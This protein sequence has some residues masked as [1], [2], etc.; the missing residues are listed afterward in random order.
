MVVLGPF[1]LQSG[2]WVWYIV[3][4]CMMAI[5][6]WLDDRFGLGIA[7]RFVVQTGAASLVAFFLL[8]GTGDREFGIA[9][10]AWFAVIV[11]VVVWVTNLYNFMDGMDGLAASQGVVVPAVMAIWFANAEAGDAALFCVVLAAA[12]AG[13]LVV[14]WHPA[15]A[16]PDTHLRAH[17]SVLDLVCLF[18]LV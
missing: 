2:V 17:D 14:N 5:L 7:T 11:A 12:G 18:F 13:L 15:M 4:F 10:V 3:P 6:G 9:Y 1:V 8:E 16:G